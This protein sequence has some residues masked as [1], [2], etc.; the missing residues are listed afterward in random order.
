[1]DIADDD[2]PTRMLF[3][4]DTALG[5]G[6]RLIGFE[7]P[8]VTDGTSLSLLLQQLQQSKQR[9]FVLI[10]SLLARSHAD[11]L[12]QVRAEGG[13]I[14]LSEVPALHSPEDFYCDIDARIESLLGSQ[15][16]APEKR[17]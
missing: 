1:M 12:E 15:A 14:V 13:H 2:Q 8:V 4:G 11:L 3:L 7:T 17:P 10:D 5:D 16:L 9:A 6:F